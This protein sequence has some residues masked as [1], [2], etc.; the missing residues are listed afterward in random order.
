MQMEMQK[1]RGPQSFRGTYQSVKRTHL[2]NGLPV[3]PMGEVARGIIRA[4]I[5]VWSKAVVEDTSRWLTAKGG[6]TPTEKKARADRRK[7]R[8]AN[9]YA[10]KLAKGKGKLKP[11]GEA[12]SGKKK[13]GGK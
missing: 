5:G 11:S 8:K 4:G 7:E 2:E 12:G 6:G 13:G 10:S 9:N 1:A 3:P